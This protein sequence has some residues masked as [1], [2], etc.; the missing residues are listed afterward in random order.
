MYRI[1]S[2]KAS[3]FIPILR[4][5]KTGAWKVW[6]R[7]SQ[8]QSRD[9]DLGATL[10]FIKL[11]RNFTLFSS[12]F[13]LTVCTLH[14]FSTPHCSLGTIDDFYFLA[15]Q[16]LPAVPVKCFIC[17][18]PKICFGNSWAYFLFSRLESPLLL[19]LI[20]EVAS[21]SDKNRYDTWTN[22]EIPDLPHSIQ[23]MFES[24][25]W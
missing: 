19:F 13:L 25:L 11:K 9:L 10:L 5:E 16:F 22:F 17:F 20:T 8:W 4:M 23:S 21:L 6:T 3:I 24:S 15:W 7:L 12:F 18:S 14:S 2:N 1:N